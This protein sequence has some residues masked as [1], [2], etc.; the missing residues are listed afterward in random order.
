MS[1]DNHTMESDR[2]LVT[3]MFADISGFTAMSEKMDPEE[4]TDIMNECFHFMGECIEHHGGTI[5][6]FIGDCVMALFGAPKALEDGPHR[7]IETALEM[8]NKLLRFNEEKHL[9]YTFEL[10]HRDQHRSC[11]SRDGGERYKTGLHSHG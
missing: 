7:A 11:H 2:R 3:V 4:V 5:D 1:G 8:R 6:K 9:P 10:S